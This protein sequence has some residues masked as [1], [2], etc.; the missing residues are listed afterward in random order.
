M[1]KGYSRRTIADL[2]HFVNGNGFKPSDWKSSGLPIIRIQNL[3]GATSFNY[4]DGPTKPDW[5]VEP[6]DL[7]YAWAGV[8][9]VSFGPTI[10]PGSK[11]VLNQ[12]IYKVVP[13]T[14][15][16]RYWLYLAL[17]HVTGKI[18]AEA[19]GFKSSLVHVHKED[20]TGQAIDVPSID[21]QRRVASLVRTWDAAID[22]VNGVIGRLLE[23]RG[24]LGHRLLSQFTRNN[25]LVRLK[26]FLTESRIAGSDGRAA[27]K[28]TIR[29][30]GKG[31]VEKDEGRAGSKNTRY[32]V[33]RKGQLIYSKLDFLNGA[34]AIIPDSLDG[35]ETTLDLPAFDISPT[36]NPLWLLEY[37]VRPSF[38]TNQV[39]LARGQRKARRVA[40]ED[41][42]ESRLRLPKRNQQD[43][44]VERLSTADH[45]IA[46]TRDLLS[47]IERQKRG[48]MQK[49][50]TAEWRVRA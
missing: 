9:G 10:W 17:K 46:L 22:A 12:H 3:N 36:V 44:V 27:K 21:E 5:L 14:H 29:L 25:K 48:I 11:G 31:A 23:R 37:L 42:L 2:C 19:H 30:Y 28:I 18:E 16:D 15:I 40:P 26:D 47:A 33:R 8:K 6:G 4:Y 41:L 13:R 49:L 7:L 39:H 45:E 20:I 32:Y 1:P 35:L 50:L 24:A 38:Y 43:E 34:I